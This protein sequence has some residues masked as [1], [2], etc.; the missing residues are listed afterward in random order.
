MYLLPLNETMWGKN[1][2][3]VL[4]DHV[5]DFIDNHDC[6]HFMHDGAPAHKTL[7]IK[8]SLAGHNIPVLD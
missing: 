3:Q 5:L 1:Y 7:A 8:S 2:V 6:S 4:R